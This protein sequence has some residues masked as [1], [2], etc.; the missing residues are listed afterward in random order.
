MKGAVEIEGE[1]AAAVPLQGSDHPVVHEQFR[2]G[3]VPSVGWSCHRG[4]W[5]S[6]T[7]DPGGSS[8][9]VVKK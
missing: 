8:S 6:Q 3:G 1:E 5:V 9:K 7:P 2:W 4:A